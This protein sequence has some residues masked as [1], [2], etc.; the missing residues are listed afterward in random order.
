MKYQL[1]RILL[2]LAF[3]LSI[4][5]P[6]GQTL[7]AATLKAAPAMHA[8]FQNAFVPERLI[9]KL[10]SVAAIQL[11]LVEGQTP[12]WQAFESLL[13]A[14]S[15]KSARKMFTDGR[16]A[17]QLSLS[18]LDGIYLVQLVPGSDVKKAVKTLSANAAVE[19]VEPDYLAFAAATTPDDPLFASQ[20][21]LTQ[22]GAQEAWDIQTGAASV[23][24][25][26]ID[27]GVDFSHPDLAGKFWT[28][29]GEIAGNGQ[30]D[31][32][33]GYID[34]VR[35]W[36]FVNGDND[37]GDDNGHGTQTAGVAGA[38][39]DNGSGIAGVCWGCSLMPVKVMQ[40]GGVANYS[41]IATGVIYAAKK[42]AR[43]INISL[44]GYSESSV[45]HAAIQ[46]ATDTYG[47]IVVAGA[48]ND[49]QSTPF[50]PA[51]YEQVLGVAAT[52]PG[53]VLTGISNFGDW[54]DVAAPGANIQTTFL[55]G[56]YGAV[57]GSSLSTAFVSGLAGLLCSEHSDWSAG[58]VRA[59]IIHTADD[60]DSLNPGF[61]DQL[62][63]GRVN[64]NQAL[65]TSS[66]PLLSFTSQTINGS[67]TA[68]P[69]PGSS[70]DFEVTLSNDW[71]DASNVQAAL[72]SSDANVSI[73]TANANYGSIPAYGSATNLTPFQFEIAASAPYGYSIPLQLHVTAG[74]GY[75][76]NI[77]LS[78]QTASAVVYPPATLTTQ[79]W[80]NDHIYILNKPVG[81]PSGSTLTIEPGTEIRNDFDYPL[82]VEGSL[83]ADGTPDQPIIFKSSL[84]QDVVGDWSGIIF[85]DSS[86]DAAFDANGHYASGSI[87]RYCTFDYFHG[88]KLEYAAP[89]ISNN[90]FLN[91]PY[92]VNGNSGPGLVI[93]DNTF[94]SSSIAV[95]G[96]GPGSIQRNKLDGAGISII[97]GDFEVASNRIIN[98]GIGATLPQETVVFT[99]NLVANN[100]IGLRVGDDAMIDTGSITITNNT[101]VSNS[102]AGI[103]LI[104]T[105]P[106]IQH[107]NLPGSGTVYA[108]QN[109]VA[110]S[111][112]STVNARQ[113]WWGTTDVTKIQA[114]I[115]DGQDEFG[116]GTVDYS[117]F[118]T[119]PGPD[120]PA[121]VMNLAISPDTTLGIQTAT[122][123]AQFSREM[124]QTI[125]PDII[126]QSVRNDTWSIFT[127]ENS[128]F[129]VENPS[130]SAIAFTPNG[131]AWIGT[132]FDGVARYDGTDWT[133]YNSTN[134]QLPSNAVLDIGIASDGSAWFAT[135]GGLAHFDGLNWTLYTTANSGLPDDEVHAIAIASNGSIWAATGSG[136]AAH[137]S[138]SSWTIYDSENS[139]LP[140]SLNEVTVASDGKVWFANSSSRVISFDGANWKTYDVK[141]SSNLLGSIGVIAQARDGKLWFGG[142]DALEAVVSYD[143]S[144]WKSYHTCSD[145]YDIVPAADGSIWIGCFG[146]ISQFDGDNWVYQ[147]DAEISSGP[148]QSIAI[149]PDGSIWSSSAKGAAVFWKLSEFSPNPGA[150]NWLD[151]KT[152]RTALD[153]TSLI[154]RDEYLVKV[155]G[156][157]GTDGIQMALT[158]GYSFTV[159]YA[160]AI[161]DITPPPKPSVSFCAGETA[162][163][164]SASWL[165]VDPQSSINLYSYAIGTT[166]GGSE[167]VDWTTSTATSMTRSNLNLISGQTYYIAVKARNAGGLW[168]EAGIPPGVKAGS[169]VCTTNV[170]LIYLPMIKN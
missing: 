52:G 59:Q 126:F 157:V 5:I 51:A 62:G 129:D 101:I 55:G 29:P 23:S 32:N 66:Q 69:E 63:S 81:I 107:N 39:T 111:I 119:A 22:I 36:D 11:A 10:D 9:L 57:D 123:E 79:T 20:W 42:G 2:V 139:E 166:P 150:G 14:G 117:D 132:W 122:F 151:S 3:I 19:W 118:L 95:D 71:A 80:T 161:S 113:N 47:A 146:G 89:F 163:S 104:G 70:V 7:Q 73:V 1:L 164:L 102:Q 97:W 75:S 41:D 149:A 131:T 152:Y 15:V 21:G 142:S 74:P 160:G 48:G 127:P 141:N 96:P 115:F 116:L 147:Y 130:V 120:N 86:I 137:F 145:V 98:G 148:V 16:A 155:E 67:A 65:S 54:V 159:D 93:S 72:S 38:A 154:P 37:P 110:S 45:L 162:S 153:I 99:G 87:V 58:M 134:S 170:R 91:G 100:N 40:A 128:G 135:A 83:I 156:A 112:A 136:G 33:N 143:G 31:D 125:A 165:V 25:A 34:D 68:R 85:K 84:S 46:A 49:N 106:L 4:A 138:G 94:K 90:S 17:K 169:G 103:H 53:D 13:P 92:G 18:A 60:I 64:A 44:G 8:A 105:S 28:N 140:D 121:Y 76:V 167:V 114:M 158:D 77:P 56:D 124:D 108:L 30:D 144:N 24:I 133:I 12:N 27:S 61:E 82:I 35:G 88:I 6:S 26:M 50:Y 78:V 43:V 168:S 109:N